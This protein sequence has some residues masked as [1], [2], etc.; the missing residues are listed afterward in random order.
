MSSIQWIRTSVIFCAAVCL[1][2]PAA[3]SGTPGTI[4]A[5]G[6]DLDEQ[7]SGAPEGSDFVAVAG[8]NFHSLALDADGGLH[9]WGANFLD[10]GMVP[11]DAQALTVEAI[12]AAAHYNLAL[13]AD[14]QIHGWGGDFE[15]QI[16][17]IPTGDN[18][19]TIAAGFRHAAAIDEDGR[20]YGWGS[21][22]VT[23]PSTF[24]ELRFQAI[25]AGYQHGVAIDTD[26]HL[27]SWGIGLGVGVPTDLQSETFQAVAA[28]EAHNVA[29][30][31]DGNLHSWGSTQYGLVT[32]TPTGSNFVSVAAGMHFSVALDSDGNL[33]A[34]GRDQFGQV[35]DTPTEGHFTSVGAG[36]FHGL[37]IEGEPVPEVI[38]A[39]IAIRGGDGPNPINLR[40][41]GMLAVVIFGS[42]DFDAL[43]VD[44]ATVMLGDPEL[45]TGI[46]DAATPVRSQVVDVDDDGHP[47][48]KLFFSVRELVELEAIDADTEALALAAALFDGTPLVGFDEVRIIA[49]GGRGN[50]DP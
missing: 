10:Q 2:L 39:E 31:T 19:A 22:Q 27:H 13:D 43:D 45:V 9:A 38:D 30:D 15:G 29:V 18:F 26:G 7:V 46:E 6:D 50:A 11:S 28:G 23:M 36:H 42:E 49:P 44:E 1:S 24:D 48:L 41:N 3:A 8:G 40:S 25:A 35:T 47:D 16:N 34:W 5:W 20:I 33:H 12:A 14:G 4:H 21:P 17:D 37:A 32:D